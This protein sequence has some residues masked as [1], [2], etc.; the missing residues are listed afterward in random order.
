MNKV[1]KGPISTFHKKISG[2]FNLMADDDFED[3][4]DEDWNE[5]DFDEEEW[6][7]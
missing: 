6:E 3:D 4:F 5:E 7:E 1:Y 2:E